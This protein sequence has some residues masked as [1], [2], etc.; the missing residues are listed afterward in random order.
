MKRV[1]SLLLAIVFICS[2]FVI[3]VSAEDDTI[4]EYEIVVVSTE[5]AYDTCRIYAD[6]QDKYYMSVYDITRY[7]RSTYTESNG[8]IKITHG[9]RELTLDVDKKSLVEN[10][11]NNDIEVITYNNQVLIHAAPLLTY[12]GATCDVSDN[13]LVIAMPSYT[14]WEALELMGDENYIRAED[15]FGSELEIKTRLLLNGILKF[16][17]SGFGDAINAEYSSVMLAL[18]VDV[19]NYDKY[20][21]TKA[22]NDIK[23]LN[24]FQSMV[25]EGDALESLVDFSDDMK[26]IHQIIATFKDPVAIYVVDEIKKSKTDFLK[27][28]TGA[29]FST[30][31]SVAETMKTSKDSFDIVTATTEHMSKDARFYNNLNYAKNNLSSLDANIIASLSSNVIMDNI[32]NDNFFD[33]I[34][35]IIDNKYDNTIDPIYFG[36]INKS[37]RLSVTE[38]VESSI[39]ISV[40]LNKAFCG[41]NSIFNYADAETNV[42]EL[43]RLKQD[44]ANTINSLA[45]KITADNYSNADD[46]E[47]F[48][49]I[50]VFYYRT[51]IAINEQFE[52]M[53]VAQWGKENQPEMRELIATLQDQSNLFAE[54]LYMLTVADCSVLINVEEIAKDN[55]W[56]RNVQMPTDDSDSTNNDTPALGSSNL[57]YVL[58]DDNTYYIVKG[59]GSSFEDANIIIP[60]TYKGL[61]VKEIAKSAFSVCNNLETVTI[62]KNIE[63]ICNQPFWF[64]PRLRQITVSSDN[65]Y[66]KS[67]DGNLYSKDGKVLL[68][69]AIGNS[70]TEF[71]IPNGVECI[72]TSA[73]EGSSTLEVINIPN[74]VENIEPAAFAYCYNLV[75]W[76]IESNP[77]Y[78]IYDY[79]CLVDVRNGSIVL[80]IANND[81]ISTDT[82]IY[83]IGESAFYGTT[84]TD[85]FIPKNIKRI[86][87]SA[88]SACRHLE[89]VIIEEGVET[90]SQYAFSYCDS[91]ETLVIPCSITTIDKNAFKDA[92]IQNVY[93]LGTETEWNNI[94]I[95]SE[96][97]EALVS[98]NINYDSNGIVDEEKITWSYDQNTSTLIISGTGTMSDYWDIAGPWSNLIYSGAIKHIVIEDGVQSIGTFA[99]SSG[100]YLSISI[101]KSVTMIGGAAFEGASIEVVYYYGTEA[102]W[103]VIRIDGYHS[104]H[105]LKNANI[106]YLGDSNQY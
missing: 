14:L 88:F 72:K 38:M 49:L 85:I 7:T 80:S 52:A 10:N 11:R 13:R 83:T 43:L 1:I 23:N 8:K 70:R 104:E 33:S 30:I 94:S 86:E 21:D 41:E 78:D 96:G 15:A 98:A 47:D 67:I 37:V 56:D 91:I 42:I 74:S 60:D 92:N 29:T 36:K 105:P 97:N 35:S 9:T 69:Y 90:I 82:A 6:A 39:K 3:T 31:S 84:I 106:V 61:P 103:N 58:S 76:N 28:W 77:F 81:F 18:Q 65:K 48:R 46:L 100:D 16:M 89:N 45:D 93:Y 101:P 32:V 5:Y 75:Y 24:L 79:R 71:S 40:L 59:I 66:Y 62:G 95:V 51:L 102:D 25:A 12:L 57:S 17:D 64:C 20:F 50:R 44:L 55:N 22:Q 27:N 34:K 26:N 2:A 19:S 73:F 68:Q 63:K 53:I 54:K 4:S 87:F 99:F